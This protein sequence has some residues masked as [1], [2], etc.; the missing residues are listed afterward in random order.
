MK[1]KTGDNVKLLAGKDRGKTGI[2]MQTFPERGLVVVEGLN[3]AV[4]HLKGNSQQ[5][6]KKVDYPAPIQVSNVALIG[7]D[8]QTGRV[9][10][11]TKTVDGKTS[12]FR[13]VKKANK[14]TRVE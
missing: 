5:K 1:I 10:V 7:K 12:K 8:G 2:V 14:Q 9:G 6:G 3:M 11:E 13:V 4:K